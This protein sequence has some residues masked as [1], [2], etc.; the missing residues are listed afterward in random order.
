MYKGTEKRKFR[1]RKHK[2]LIK[3]QK[4]NS[5]EW[6]EGITEDLGAGG[7]LFAHSKEIDVGSTLD[8]EIDDAEGIASIKRAG[9]VVRREDGDDILKAPAFKYAMEFIKHD[10]KDEEE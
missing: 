4:E 8:M 7:V 6:E 2:S 3:F 1:R 9:K 10:E 5:D